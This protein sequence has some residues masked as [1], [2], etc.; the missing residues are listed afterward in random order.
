MKGPFLMT[1]GSS[2][3]SLCVGLFSFWTSSVPKTTNKFPKPCIFWKQEMM[4]ND[5]KPNMYAKSYTHHLPGDIR[6]E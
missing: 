1:V 2:H 5:K 3:S 6:N 4:S